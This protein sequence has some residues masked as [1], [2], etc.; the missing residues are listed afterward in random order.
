MRKCY[1]LL[2]VTLLL[3]L[4][5]ACGS[6]QSSSTGTTSAIGTPT[7]E[8]VSLSWVAPS[9]RTD[10]SYLS[11]TDLAGYRI[12]VGTS[13]T[14]L[15]PLVDLNDDTITQY[16]INTLSAGEYYFAVSAYD[17][18]GLESSLSQVVLKQVG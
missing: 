14:S 16:T 8:S 2:T 12:Y 18:D 11:T 17:K 7:G 6:Q 4:L 9:T 13:A 5:S 1:Q 3:A 15:T 10:G